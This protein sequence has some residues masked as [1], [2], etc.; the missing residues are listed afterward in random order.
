MFAGASYGE[1]AYSEHAYTALDSD[2]FEAFLARGDA[3][4]CWILEVDAFALASV[5]ARSGAFA[6][7]AF[8]ELGFGDAEAGGAPG[9]STLR[10]SSHG[11]TSHASD[12]PART[13]HDGRIAADPAIERSIAGRTGMA[14]LARASAQVALVNTDGG[15][16][17]L[18][19]DYALDG[20]R[21]RLLL[22]DPDGPLA[23][24]GVVFTGVVESAPVGLKRATFQLSDGLARLDVPL[25]DTVY[26]GTGG[27]E[28]GAD[29]AGKPKPVAHGAVF[30]VAAP[31]V[32]AAGLVYQ[33][34][35]GAIQDVPAAYDRGVEL[36]QVGGAPAG[37]EYS[38]DTATGLVTLGAT[39]DGTVTFDVEGDAPAAGY[40]ERT[41]DIAQRLLAIAGL[42]SGEIEPLSFGRLNSD[43]GASVGQWTGAEPATVGERLGELLAG[44]GA[45]GGFNRHGAF[46]VGVLK[47]AAG[48]PVL[49]LAADEILDLEREPA[50]EPVAPRVW[51]TLVGWQK[52]Y[53]VQSDLAAGVTDARRTFAAEAF[54]VAESS[55]AAIRSRHLLARE[56]GPVPALYAE[57]ADAQA[58]ALRLFELWSGQRAFF[59]VVTGWR[60]L[61]AD[62]GRVV[63][64]T[65]PR[66]GLALGR[67]GVVLRH[68]VSAG[69]VEILWMT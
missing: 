59:R 29:L 50:P 23:D 38:V 47:A 52:N 65:H 43:A 14:G 24:F 30:N 15:L 48:A 34:H 9:V 41:A 69:R 39:P 21:A 2:G 64:I 40:V 61:V 35:D 68:A 49:E 17:T 58:E 3:R 31:L 12:T 11:Y 32:D 22:G 7:A 25:N 60:A 6:D 28:G 19:R 54:R 63:K 20:R 56:Y 42:A 27:D 8:G 26:A 44:V 57:E 36:T 53:T 5:E 4:R 1:Y 10:F 37:G 13:W 62:I 55:D 18:M 16:D 67:S 46:E 51:R 45:F 66:H 33:V